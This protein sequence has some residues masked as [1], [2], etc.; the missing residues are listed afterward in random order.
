[1]TNEDFEAI[2]GRVAREFHDEYI[3]HHDRATD[4]TM[5]IA[6]DYTMFILERFSKLVEEY[7]VGQAEGN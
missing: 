5:K 4:D 1:M 2:V 3:S 6:V 7:E